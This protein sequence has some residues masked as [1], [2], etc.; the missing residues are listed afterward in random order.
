MKNS[1]KAKDANMISTLKILSTAAIWFKKPFSLT[2][3][4]YT[5]L[6]YKQ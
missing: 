3:E 1:T 6:A 2:K 5:C 4:I